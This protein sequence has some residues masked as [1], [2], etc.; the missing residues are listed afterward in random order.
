[1]LS[2]FTQVTQ[3]INRAPPSTAWINTFRVAAALK[4]VGTVVAML[5][6]RLNSGTW[7]WERWWGSMLTGAILLLWLLPWHT[8]FRHPK[9]IN[10]QMISALI[11]TI[12]A[13]QLDLA[14][15]SYAP[16]GLLLGDQRFQL[17]VGW[18]RHD[19]NNIHSL[20]SLFVM[21]PV[22]LASWHYSYWGM[23][24]SMGLAGLLYLAAPLW[25]PSDS[26]NWWFYGVRGF[27]MLGT[28]LILA[29]IV[30]N[31]AIEQ[32][33][34]QVALTAANAKLS[35][36]A[37]VMEQLATSRERNRLARELH[38]TLAHSLSGTAVQ[39]E[40]VQVLLNVDPA[41]AT[42]ELKNARDQI[43]LGLGEARRAITALR[44]TP[45][46]EFGLAEAL[47]QRI[48]TI[49]ERNQITPH[50]AISSP[51]LLLPH[52]EQTLYRITEEALIN[53]EKHAEA[54]DLWVTLSN[55]TE[56]KKLTLTIRDN[57]RGF[58]PTA[59]PP[60]AHFGLIGMH[61]RANL[62]NGILSIDSKVDVG[63]T[64][65]LSLSI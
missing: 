42:V 1:M 45:L 5:T 33:R 9:A 14:Q 12:V 16:Y 15:S 32:R 41:A 25:L 36:Q 18:D 17:L 61:E 58:D 34:K 37:I 44:A 27:V 23:W 10:V 59:Q 3:S 52:T 63:T 4:I 48:Q 50:I 28:T 29:Y 21:V 7:A 57:G 49:A 22:I 60:S 20:G 19:V 24:S 35:E 8:L 51:P 40:A 55:D 26:F 47:R 62:I 39:L 54:A 2:F 56:Q 53:I 43:R 6:A 38:D 31:L 64:I 46:E 11:F 30:T 65:N 13:H